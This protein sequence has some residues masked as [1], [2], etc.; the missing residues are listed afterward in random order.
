VIN[1]KVSMVLSA[2]AVVALLA[3]CATAPEVPEQTIEERA[4]ARWDYMVA[5]QPGDAWQYL[6]PGYRERTGRD[7]YAQ[8]MQSRPVRWLSA[9]VEGAECD[10]DRCTVRTS[11][12]YNVPS[13]PHGQ[14]KIVLQ[15]TI[16]ENWIRLDGQWWHVA[17]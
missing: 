9:E 2:V 7:R 1:K 11:V 16:S 15:R 17:D 6:T 5:R 3:G 14:D 4:Q 10:Q 13:A 8:I 12:T